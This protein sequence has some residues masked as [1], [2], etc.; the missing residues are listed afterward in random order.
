MRQKVSQ[1]RIGCKRIL[2][3]RRPKNFCDRQTVLRGVWKPREQCL[4]PLMK[5]QL[6]PEAL[7]YRR[8]NK[9]GVHCVRTIDQCSAIVALVAPYREEFNLPNICFRTGNHG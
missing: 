9:S 7:I 6:R 3:L 8:I 2:E 5:G 1:F 4:Q